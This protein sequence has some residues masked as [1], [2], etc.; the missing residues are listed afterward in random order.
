MKDYRKREGSKNYEV[1][2]KKKNKMYVNGEDPDTITF[3]TNKSKA[4]ETDLCRCS[5][6]KIRSDHL[7][8]LITIIYSIFCLLR[9]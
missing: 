9:K 8:H 3:G 4:V 5:F 6:W 7:V 1:I 2:K